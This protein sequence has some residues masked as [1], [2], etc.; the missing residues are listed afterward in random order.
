[1][2]FVIDIG[3]TQTVL[4]AYKEEKLLRDWRVGTDRAKTADEYG[5]L[6]QN[7]FAG[8]GIALDA[9]TGVAISCVV[10][11]L[12]QTFEDFSLRYLKLNPL[13]IGPGVKTGMPILMD[14]PK[15]VGADRIVNS[16][17][18]FQRLQRAC[19]VVDFGTATTFDCISGKG[20][21]IGGVIAP[22]I[23]ISSEALFQRAS[24]LPR[25]EIVRPRTVIGKN[26]VHGMQSGIFYGYVCVV[27][28]M[29]ERIR[30]EMGGEA[31][32][33]ATGGLAE[34][35]APESRSIQEVDRYLTLEGLRILYQIN[36]KEEE[37]EKA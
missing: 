17:A 5:V 13:V 34:R 15:E 9:F 26:T 22:G 25:V 14:N 4:G 21:Y 30:R 19:I 6:V 10:P 36:R 16:V 24:K 29:V 1:M 32:V 3:N 20:E 37:G 33:L 11:S 7:L 31:Y 28:G 35:I 23:G 12:T 18:A 8:A 27:D 2:L